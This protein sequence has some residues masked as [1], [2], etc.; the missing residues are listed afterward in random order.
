MGQPSTDVQR[1]ALHELG[2]TLGLDH[3]DEASPPQS[4]SADMNSHISDIDSLTADDIAGGQSLYGPPESPANDNFV[5]AIALSGS[6][7]TGTGFNTNATK[8]SGE[9]NH[10]GNTGGRSV[11]W[12]WTAPS[13][14]TVT[15]TTQG[16]VFDTTLGVY[17]GP[18]VGALTTIASNDDTT[19]GT[20]QYSTVSFHGD[21]W[22]HVFFCRGW[23]QCRRRPWRRLRLR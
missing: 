18:G 1:V 2:H 6:S 15:L 23:L 7:A 16:S 8:E 3:P 22:R 17:T 21:R 5:S 10:A 11:W 20:V 14:G 9:P 4:V 19:S 13:G 12:K